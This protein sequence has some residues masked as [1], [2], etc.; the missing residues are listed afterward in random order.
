MKT[1][2]R[3]ATALNARG[4]VALVA[5]LAFGGFLGVSAASSPRWAPLHTWLATALA[6]AALTALACYTLAWRLG[7]PRG[8]SPQVSHPTITPVETPCEVR[9]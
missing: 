4:N 1:S 6:A 8:D 9:K 5:A 3:R 7:S 2:R